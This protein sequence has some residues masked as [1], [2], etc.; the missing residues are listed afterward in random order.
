M[1]AE[2]DSNLRFTYVTDAYA[3]LYGKERLEILGKHPRD[4]MSEQVYA[5]VKPKLDAS[6]KGEAFKYDLDLTTIESGPDY[7]EAAYQ[8]ELDSAGGLKRLFIVVTDVTEHRLSLNI[9]EKLEARLTAAHR[10]SPDGFMVFKALRDEGGDITDFIWEYA[11]SA[12]AEMVGHFIKDLIGSR[13]LDRLPGNKEEGLFDAYIEVVNTG[14][15]FKTVRRYTHDGL[16]FWTEITAIKLADG[17][18]VSFS[19]ISENIQRDLEIKENERRLNIALNAARLGVWD[20]DPAA[21][22]SERSLRHDEIFGYPEGKKIWSQDDFVDHISPDY[23]EEMV[24]EIETALNQKKPWNFVTQ[25][26]TADGQ[27]KWVSVHGEPILDR[28]GH[29]DRLIGTI[30]DITARKEAETHRDLLV[31]ELNHRVKNSLATIQAIAKQTMR[32]AVD[33]QA[34][35][36]SFNAR[37]RAISAAHDILMTDSTARADINALIRKQVRPYA[38]SEDQ[39]DIADEPVILGAESAHGLGLVLH[40]LATN[41]AKYGALSKEG[42]RVEIRTSVTGGNQVS[43]DW[44]E[45]GGPTVSEPTQTGFGSR[46]IKQSIEYSLGGSVSVIYKKEGVEAHLEFLNSFSQD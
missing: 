5:Q 9:A 6:L 16:D 21:K 46:L 12:G 31:R 37:L 30:E 28:A 27:L 2:L 41:A 34:F 25:I 19:D 42:G 32:S 15:A 20:L 38:P 22:T 43:L 3:A 45:T 26:K 17:I 39:L 1:I 29:V 44:R 35:E 14:R 8:P 4:L 33:M 13:M 23:R 7:V 36:T 24:A 10:L 11:N 18:A 40:E